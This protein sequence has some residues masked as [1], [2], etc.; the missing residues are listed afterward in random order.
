MINIL[1]VTGVLNRG[2]AELMLLDIVK[3]L[4]KKFKV[5]ILINYKKNDSRGGVGILD[6]DFLACGCTL[7]YIPSQVDI[8]Y[9]KYFRD[10]RSVIQIIGRVEIIHTHINTKSGFIALLAY[11]HRI[12]KIITHSH[13]EIHYSIRSFREAAR[14]IEFF[15]QKRLINR[16]STDF[17][18]CSYK[19][20]ETVFNSTNLE[21]IKVIKNAIDINKFL[22]PNLDRINEIRENLA[23]PA[24]TVILGTAGRVVTRKNL[25]FTIEVLHHLKMKQLEFVFL[26]VGQVDDKNYYKTVMKRVEEYGLQEHFI[27]VGLQEN[28]EHYYALMDIFISGAQ[29]EAFGMVAIEAQASNC[30]CLLSE[31]YPRDVDMDLGLV[32]FVNNFNAEIWAQ[33]LIDMLPVNKRN[34]EN[35]LLKFQSNG[36]DIRTNIKQIEK[37]YNS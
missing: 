8:G 12:P 22:F 30:L 32:Q 33:K 37:N 13:G 27:A 14:K 9:L 19:A 18:A 5:S 28:V 31:G 20:G 2:G 4:S 35:I 34:K 26:N 29:N 10:F 15:V 7:F 24:H 11:Y 36:F 17:W 25:L 16:F 21:R 23:L 3:N 1:Y 6:S